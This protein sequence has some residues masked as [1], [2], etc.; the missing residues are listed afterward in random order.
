M[1]FMTSSN[2]MPKCRP[3]ALSV[4]SSPRVVARITL[5]TTAATLHPSMGQVSSLAEL[6]RQAWHPVCPQDERMEISDNESIDREQTGHDLKGNT[7]LDFCKSRTPS[8]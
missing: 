3:V 2:L 8:K 7:P 6:A 1:S 4:S 5:E